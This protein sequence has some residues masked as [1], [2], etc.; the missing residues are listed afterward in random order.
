MCEMQA[1][2]DMVDMQLTYVIL[3]GLGS[4]RSTAQERSTSLGAWIF[5]RTRE[6]MGRVGSERGDLC[7]GTREGGGEEEGLEWILVVAE[8][9]CHHW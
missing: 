3:T 2:Y 7:D 6:C 1:W 8:N 9:F 5:A 4:G